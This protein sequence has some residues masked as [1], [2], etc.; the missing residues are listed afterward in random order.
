MKHLMTTLIVSLA[1]FCCHA[2]DN[3]IDKFIGEFH[4]EVEISSTENR[5]LQV[6]VREI[7]DGLT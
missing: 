4:G 1:V 7:K 6:I 2:N 5:T 3:V